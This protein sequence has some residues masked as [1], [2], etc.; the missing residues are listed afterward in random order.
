MF[1]G[2]CTQNIELFLFVSPCLS[3]RG[4]WKALLWVLPH[5]N[6][7][8]TKGRWRP[9][10]LLVVWERGL[11]ECQRQVRY[12]QIPWGSLITVKHILCL[13]SV[14]II[15]YCNFAF[16][17]Q[18]NPILIDAIKVSPAHRARYFWGNIPGMNRCVPILNHSLFLK[19]FKIDLKQK[20]LWLFSLDH[21]LRLWMTKCPSRIVWK[22]DAW[23]R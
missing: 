12:L 16:F 3:C 4:H 1:S 14:I 2:F 22:L 13:A 15:F 21:L 17:P 7:V 23:Q 18:C 8:E 6:L 20:N 5:L 9:S 19:I 10:I 11:H